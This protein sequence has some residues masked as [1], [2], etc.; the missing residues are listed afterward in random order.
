[1]QL[2]HAVTALHDLGVL[3]ALEK[4]VTAEATA[5]TLRLDCAMLRGTLE[6]VS[7]RTDL[8]RKTGGQFVATRRYSDQVCFLLD[9]YALAYGRNAV[10]LSNLLRQPSLA[11]RTV[12]RK[13]LARAFDRAGSRGLGVLPG[14]I[15]QLGLGSVL[16]L[17]CGSGALLLEMAANDPKFIGWGLEVDATMCKVARERI[18]AAGMGNQV[19]VLRG[20]ANHVRAALPRNV[21]SGIAALTASQF[22]NELFSSGTSRAVTWMRGLRRL[23]PR[24]PMFIAD[25]YGRLGAKAGKTRR[26]NLVH[27]FAQLISGQGI[28]PSNRD[29]WAAIYSKAGCR[30]AHV[31]EDNSTTLFVHIVVL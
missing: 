5:R 23:F 30:L 28:P 22:A 15:R 11:S 26:E 24:R 1:M 6:Y 20:D 18:R 13:H 27:D 16:D 25:Y 31:I 2:A 4:P 17:G 12:E 9:V 19:H 29:Q 3:D 14:I 7:A 10:Q 21:I 8:V